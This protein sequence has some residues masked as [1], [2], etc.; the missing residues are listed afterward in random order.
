MGKLTVQEVV[1]LISGAGFRCARGYPGERMPQIQKPAVAVN[2]EREDASSIT[3]A[4]H[5]LS[6]VASGAC[7]CEDYA[8]RV[9][10]LL[11]NNGAACVQE[12]CQHDGRGDRFSVR[13]LAVWTVDPEDCPFTV[14]MGGAKLRYAVKFSATREISLEPAGAMG[15]SEPA[16]ILR[17]DLGWTFTLEER[18]PRDTA[19]PSEVAE[20]FAILVRRGTVG[21]LYDGCYWRSVLREDDETGLHQVRIGRAG[22]RSV[23][24]YG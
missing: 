4:V 24:T 19:E 23:L 17:K 5:V 13:I 12:G 11:R 22:S 18:F 10:E 2:P 3:M 15:Q 21:E 6:P 9:A 16:G 8:R 20:P 1:A 7:T 14:S